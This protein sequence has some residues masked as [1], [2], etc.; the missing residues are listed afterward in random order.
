MKEL[1][2]KLFRDLWKMKGQVLAIALVIVSGVS[3]FVM[4]IST[5]NSLNLTRDRFYKDYRFAEVFASLKRAPENIKDRISDIPGVDQVETRVVADVKLDIEDFPEPVTA[6]IVSVPDT[7]NPLLNRL[8][9]RKGRI[10]DPFK[11]NEVVVSEGFAEAHGFSPGDTFAAVINGKWKKLTIVGIALSPEFIIQSRPGALS[12]DYKRYAI[13]WMGRDALGTAYDMK[14]AFNDISLTISPDVNANDVLAQLDNL[15]ERYG[16]LGSYTRENQISHRFLTEEFR[17]LQRS[18][19][20]FPAIFIAVAAFLLN[21]VVSR[22]I[23]TQREQIAALKAFGYSNLDVGIHYIKM[24]IAVV[25]IGVAGGIALGVWLGKG[26]GMIYMEFYR[27]PYFIYELRPSVVIIV[28][29]ITIASAVA[30]TLYSVRKAVKL[31]PAEAMRP[32]P[33]ALYRKM[34]IERTVLWRLLSHPTHIIIRNITRRPAK[35]FLSVTGIALACAI[36]L[37]ATFSSDA[38]DIMVNVQFKLSQKEDMTATFVEPTSRRAANELKGIRGIEHVEGF[39]SVPV[40]LSFM[41]RSYRTSIDGVNPDNKLRFLLDTNLET[42]HL[43]PEGLVLTDYLGDILG[44]RPGD[45]L[46]VEVLEGSRPVLH[47]PVVGLVKQYIGLSGYMDIAALNRIMREGDAISGTYFTVDSLYQTE[48]YR[49]LVDMPGV[50][51]AIVRKD[52]I[53]NF[54]ETQAEFFLFFTFVAS[55]LAGTIAFGVVYNTAR[56][57]LAERGHEL[58]SLRVLGYTRAE[59]S[60]ILLGE[61]GMLTI[62]AIPL[63]FLIGRGICAYI[64]RA[65]GSDLFRIP[66][67]LEPA[68]YSLAA[69]V[70][71]A[72]ACLSGLIVRHRLDR[73]DLVAVLKIKE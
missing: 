55:I 32:E 31:S 43:P 13:L 22:T 30:G 25:L 10:V 57:A 15:L 37:A 33:P 16:G 28:M 52:E 58:A 26:L 7:G 5:M 23:S 39:R 18:S 48:I 35:S 36:M 17:Q 67:V 70:V 69:A 68:T 19:E 14:G 6:R 20:I 64:A 2:R 66:V 73:L 72:S 47:V 54:Y 3:A 21:V 51:G 49:K 12:P 60:Y 24:V 63:G 46:T 1:D 41:N 38:V 8:Y 40:R 50:S 53:K 11:D 44:I 62:S 34:F 27:F 29:F 42:V 56:I 4:L 71:V 61:L 9:I 59:I 65:L 45:I